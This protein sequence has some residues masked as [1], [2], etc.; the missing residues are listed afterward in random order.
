M[1]GF[2]ASRLG[3]DP[4][5]DM[6]AVDWLVLT[7]HSVLEVTAGPIFVDQTT[8]LARV[9]ATLRWYPPDVER[10]VLAAGWQ[11]L[12]Q[13]MPMVWPRGRTW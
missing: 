2:A 7:G 12:S 11:R 10:Y 8:E 4:T 5:G 13:Q 9:R 3:V 6:S 1:A